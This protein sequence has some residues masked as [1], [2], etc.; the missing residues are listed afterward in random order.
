MSPAYV[1][2]K[3]SHE[4][5]R[6][7]FFDGSSVIQ[8]PSSSLCCSKAE[9]TAP[10]ISCGA[11]AYKELR[12]DYKGNDGEGCNVK[13]LEENADVYIIRFTSD[14]NPS[15]I[16]IPNDGHPCTGTGF[17]GSENHLIPEYKYP[18]TTPTDGAIYKIDADG[19]EIMVGMWD[20]DANRFYPVL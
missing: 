19:N 15:D 6:G 7:V 9:D 10:Y 18:A 16:G 4:I 17:T 5:P 2:I 8:L 13:E 12:L 14:T 3:R 11:D 20:K 1:G